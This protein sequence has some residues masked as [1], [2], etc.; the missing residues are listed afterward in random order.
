[1]HSFK[2]AALATL[3]ALTG[4]QSQ[5]QVTLHPYEAARINLE[6]ARLANATA[7]ASLRLAPG[8]GAE[9]SRAGLSSNQMNRVHRASWDISQAAYCLNTERL[10]ADTRF[11]TF[12]YE[13]DEVTEC[14]RHLRHASVAL[15][16]FASFQYS[17]YSAPEWRDILS[18]DARLSGYD[19]VAVPSWHEGKDI[20]EDLQGAVKATG[21]M[22]RAVLR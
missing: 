19:L 20:G 17:R 12:V 16:T 3:V 15:R 8:K 5:P 10:P 2:A 18:H 9:A 14:Y 22:V 21:D 7:G 1:M 4:C 6:L 11:G 13:V